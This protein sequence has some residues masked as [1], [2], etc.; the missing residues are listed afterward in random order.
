MA[1]SH[2]TV[3][4]SSKVEPRYLY[5]WSASPAI[6][7]LVNESTTGSTNQQELNLTTIKAIALNLPSRKTQRA[8]VAKVDELMSLCDELEASLKIRTAIEEAFSSVS[9]QLLLT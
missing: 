5:F 2:V 6:Q 8:I 3:L 9:G 4:R 7:K 1:D